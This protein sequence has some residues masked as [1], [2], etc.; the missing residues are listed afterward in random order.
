MTKLCL[1][2]GAGLLI[3]LS[4]CKGKDD[5]ASLGPGSTKVVDN[6]A[7]FEADAA[8]AMNDLNMVWDHEDVNPPEVI[9]HLDPLCKEKGIPFAKVP[10]KEDLGAAAGLQVGTS[11]VAVIQEGEAKDIIKG[12]AGPTKEAKKE[13]KEKPAKE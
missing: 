13:E 12:L 9:M 8:D 3:Y 5:G 10:S 2:L 11:S 7:C 4:G 6:Y 1:T